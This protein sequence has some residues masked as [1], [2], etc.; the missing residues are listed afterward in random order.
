MNKHTLHAVLAAVLVALSMVAPVAAVS[1]SPAASSAPPSGFVTIPDAAVNSDVP[2]HA[3]EHFPDASAFRGSVMTT[4]GA[5]T[6]EMT[7]TTETRAMGRSVSC[8]PTS[9][10]NQTLDASTAGSSSQQPETCTDPEFAIILSDDI[11]HA[12]RWV[13]VNATALEEAVGYVPE[14]AYGLHDS[15]ER[16]RSSIR[17]QGRLAIWYVPEFSTNTVTFS[18]EINI[19]DS[20]ASD[21]TQHAYEINDLDA[22]SDPNV[23]FTGWLN[24]ETEWTNRTSLQ[25]GETVSLSIA[26]NA[27]PTNEKVVFVGNKTVEENNYACSMGTNVTFTI[28]GNG[29]SKTGFNI[30]DPTDSDT[31]G[32]TVKLVIDGVNVGEWSIA[33]DGSLSVL[34]QDISQGTHDVKVQRTSGSPEGSLDCNYI[35]EDDVFQTEDPS[36]TFST[37]ETVSVTGFLNDGEKVTRTV[38]LSTSTSS[39]DVSV[40]ASVGVN[41]SVTERTQT[42][43][44]SL[45]VN[46]HW[47]NY[48]GA[49]SDGT[50][51]TLRGNSSW[52]QAETNRVNVSVGNGA[53]SAD[54]P[55]P[56]VKVN[57]AHDTRDEKGVSYEAE[58][59]SERYNVSKTF[60]SERVNATLTIPHQGT[61]IA[62]RSLEYRINESGGWTTVASADYQLSGTTLEVDLDGVYGGDIPTN[63]TIEIRSVA[64]KVNPYNASISVLE[65]TPV[66]SDIDS[67]IKLKSWNNDSYLGVSNDAQGNW[68]HYLANASWSDEAAYAK[69]DTQGRQ[70][71]FLPNAKAGATTR[72]KTIPVKVSPETNE[73]LVKVPNPNKTAPELV[74]RP[75]AHA[76]DA[77]AYTFVSATSGETY[78]LL[79]K[80]DDVQVDSAE[81]SSPVTLQGSDE[82]ATLLITQESSGSSSSSSDGDGS[83]G[84]VGPI[85]RGAPDDVPFGALVTLG[86]GV[87]GLV[88]LLL[89]F[90]YLGW[91]VRSEGALPVHPIF[92]LL[93]AVIVVVTFDITSGGAIS[94]ALGFGVRTVAPLAFLLAVVLAAYWFYRKFILGAPAK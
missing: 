46:G 64:S 12:G 88:G 44:P 63:T 20:P 56:L 73:V 36:V 67:K 6:L 58:A 87:A 81:A 37:G 52:L 70:R 5:E 35:P 41:L 93:A 61:V 51:T 39:Y 4:R 55:E 89:L 13:A 17:R 57:Y 2:S 53:L 15:G 65:V 18:G 84:V 8:S 19:T 21:G 72:V 34:N 42:V 47:L 80:T 7:I 10:D 59:L 26:G 9:S 85:D 45:E 16:W 49:L 38:N 33:D 62:M 27:E 83:T 74:V 3:Q 60:A 30:D 22:A 31:D 54:A 66:G 91:P 79:D 68:V 43:D 77:V 94:S 78:L 86:V 24:T 1:T 90:R 28:D 11:D 82:K 71:L 50:S 92:G 25:K 14:M 32:G 40:K 69:F 48:T 29:D 23:T 75:G 76:G